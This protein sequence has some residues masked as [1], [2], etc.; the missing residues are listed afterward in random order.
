[1]AARAELARHRDVLKMTLAVR[2]AVEHGG[3]NISTGESVGADAPFV[4]TS[5]EIEADSLLRI[6]RYITS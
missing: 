4:I 3:G 6:F 5:S 1:M 2:T